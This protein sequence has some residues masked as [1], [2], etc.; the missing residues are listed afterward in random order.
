[1]AKDRQTSIVIVN[2]GTEKIIPQ[3][4]S[5][6]FSEEMVIYIFPEQSASTQYI[7]PLGDGF[8]STP[9]QL[10]YNRADNT[11]DIAGEK[12]HQ[13][14]FRL[15]TDAAPKTIKGAASWSFNEAEQYLDILIE[16]SRG[17]LVIQ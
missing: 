7:E 3:G 4:D 17:K 5:T 15:K 16:C 8:Y 12:N 14:T 13:W 10:S 11:I 1:H 2:P 9:V 6:S